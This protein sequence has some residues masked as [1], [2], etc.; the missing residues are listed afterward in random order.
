MDASGIVPAV[1]M[2]MEKPASWEDWG[3]PGGGHM[4]YVQ[5]RMLGSAVLQEAGGERILFVL[6]HYPEAHRF[7]LTF[8]DG[9]EKLVCLTE[10]EDVPVVNGRAEV[11]IDRKNCQI[12][13]VE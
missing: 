2:G 4:R 10:E 1:R 9:A 11:E 13:R 8:R 5:E 3:R 7:T 12:Y 6:N